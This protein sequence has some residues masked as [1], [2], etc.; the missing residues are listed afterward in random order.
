MDSARIVQ[1]NL[2]ANQI[3]GSEVM[4]LQYMVWTEGHSLVILGRPQAAIEGRPQ[5][6]TAGRACDRADQPQGGPAVETAVET[7]VGEP[8][9]HGR[10]KYMN[11]QSVRHTGGRFIALLVAAVMLATTC[12]A[13]WP[14]TGTCSYAYAA[15]VPGE[16]HRPLYRSEQQP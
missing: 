11:H 8:S 14:V 4:V 13:S 3:Y 9:A 6:A 7:A 2:P 16:D 12:L 1:L 15:E 10:R 5:A